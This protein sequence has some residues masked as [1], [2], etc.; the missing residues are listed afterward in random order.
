MRARIATFV[1]V[2]IAVLAL[3]PLPANSQDAEQAASESQ[4][5]LD[6]RGRPDKVELNV[7][8]RMYIW[9][10]GGLWH[11]RT[12]SS[13]KGGSNFI[14]AIT[15]SDGKIKSCRANAEYKVNKKAKK[16]KGVIKTNDAWQVTDDR[17]Q[18]IF[19]FKTRSQFDGFVFK[20]SDRAKLEFR[21]KI[22]GKEAAQRVFLGKD[23]EH[24]PSI[25]FT[26]VADPD[27]S[28]S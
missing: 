12:T 7:P 25:P 15:V 27:K 20:V 18:L 4:T 16:K 22:D 13:R 11:L 3:A 28:E 26:L 6:A 17:S 19:Q 1:A 5:P 23:G 8:A 21:L 10:S 24:P 9:H 14:G 2:V